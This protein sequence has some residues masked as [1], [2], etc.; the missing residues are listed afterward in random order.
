MTAVG[1]KP[2]AQDTNPAE[3]ARMLVNPSRRA[4]LSCISPAC[5]KN[6]RPI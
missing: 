2:Q 3:G 1:L 4:V 5:I 6:N